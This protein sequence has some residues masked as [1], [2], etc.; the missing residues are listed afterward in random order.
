MRK[1]WVT[2]PVTIEFI[3]ELEKALVDLKDRWANGGF[4]DRSADGTIQLNST[5]IGE[6]QAYKSIL[7]MIE[8]IA[9]A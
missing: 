3:K 6:A 8:D 4:T 9:E 5:S 1:E 7:Q 2:H